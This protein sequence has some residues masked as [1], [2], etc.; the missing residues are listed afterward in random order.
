MT[1]ERDPRTHIVLSWLREDAHENAER[2]LLRALDEVDTTPQRRSSGP[3][4][5]SDRMNTYAKLI[6]AAA[7]VL[8]VAVVGYQ[9][10]PE[11]SGVGAPTT[12]PSPSPTLLARGH[13]SNHGAAIE[14]DATGAGFT[15]TGVMT[16][17][18]EGGRFSVDLQCT[19]TTPGGLVVI[20][21]ITTESTHSYAPKGTRAAIVLQPGS[22]VRAYPH[23]E[24]PDPPAATCLTFLGTVTDAG[25]VGYLE[26]IDGTLELGASPSPS[27]VAL[28]ETEGDPV[29]TYPNAVWSRGL[30]ETFTSAIYGISLRYPSGWTVRR[31]TQP[32]TDVSLTADSPAADVIFDSLSAD[33]FIIVASQPRA[34]HPADWGGPSS[35]RL[36]GPGVCDG[37]GGGRFE[38]DGANAFDLQCE[39]GGTVDVWTATRGYVII[40]S[41]SAP[42]GRALFNAVLPTVDLRPEDAVDAKPSELP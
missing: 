22:P 3:A 20:G 36:R 19:R 13:F 37:G 41:A 11:R 15:A 31:A 27:P 10:L 23:F 25:G 28:V 39:R 7:A 40:A 34:L 21:G 35:A 42:E 12:T 5:R 33:S 29:P 9:F 30:D 32:W 16:L 38:V 6:A 17:S 4:R 14:L 26:P 2:M 18:D 24:N 1:L 8:V